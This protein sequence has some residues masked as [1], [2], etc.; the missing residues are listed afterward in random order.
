VCEKEKYRRGFVEKL[1][2]RIEQKKD[3]PVIIPERKKRQQNSLKG[4]INVER[5]PALQKIR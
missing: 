3:A 2:C 4:Q 1:S 5:C